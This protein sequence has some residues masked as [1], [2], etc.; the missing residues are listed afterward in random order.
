MLDRLEIL[1]IAKLKANNNYFVSCF[2]N[3]DPVFNK[4][5]KYMIY[6]KSMIKN[7][8]EKLDKSVSKK[9]KPDIEK[10]DN[11][12]FNNKRRFKKGLAVISSTGADFWKEFHFSIGLKNEIII[13]KVP[14]IKPLIDLIDRYQRYVVM[15]IDKES[16]R[17]FLVHLGEIE[18]YRE[19]FTENVPGKHKKGGWFSLS[20]RSFERH[21]DY[22][23]GLHIKDVVRHL[24]DM[25]SSGDISR[26]V[27]GGPEEAIT[28]AKSLLTKQISDKI[29]GTCHVGISANINEVLARVQPI[30]EKYENNVKNL[31]IG[32]LLTKT[33]KKENAVLGVDDVLAAL[34]EG[35]VMKLLFLK[36]YRDSGYSCLRCGFLTSQEIVACPYCKKEI[37]KVDH[38]IDLAVQKAIEQGAAVEVVIENKKFEK[39]GSVGAF[40]RY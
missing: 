26:L 7:T 15:I 40:L 17:L 36:D 5:A 13:D 38:I 32:E 11:Y 34:Q 8:M 3:V 25:L 23:V 9:V 33:M 28:M 31:I 16:A 30:L 19:I 1:K 24:E 12:I 6:L 21:I 4:K 20:E 29:I 2:L 39:A 27:V 10:I 37:R 18:E 22:H 35:R 14:Y